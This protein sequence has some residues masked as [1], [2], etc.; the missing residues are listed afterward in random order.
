MMQIIKI[1]NS[2]INKAYVSE[3]EK[4][5]K[6]NI[7]G[8]YVDVITSNEDQQE[9]ITTFSMDYSNDEY[10]DAQ[11]HGIILGKKLTGFDW[12]VLCVL[13][14]FWENGKDEITFADIARALTQDD[15]NHW[16][17]P[18]L[19]Q[20]VENSVRTL[21]YIHATLILD[22]EKE[23]VKQYFINKE[24]R[25]HSTNIVINTVLLHA[26]F[27]DIEYKNG[28]FAKGFK[29]L[30]EPI[31]L[32]YCKAT[33]Q[34]IDADASIFKNNGMRFTAENIGIRIYFAS[35]LYARRIN[36]NM[37][38]EVRYDTI[39]KSVNI[40]IKEDRLWKSRMR[41]KIHT[42]LDGLKEDNLISDYS[43]DNEKVTIKI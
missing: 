11:K 8:G 37:S 19:I 33:H 13:S 32:T 39:L 29:I 14:T 12:A 3:N 28:T 6:V 18:N 22:N 9:Y 41:S 42:I 26:M 38:S 23:E 27:F 16:V 24:H 2:K 17:R 7:N 36:Q 15:G 5:Q 40:P 30:S 21:Q 35:Y 1:Q 31:L 10:D 20:A 34:L 4:F 25:R 43:K